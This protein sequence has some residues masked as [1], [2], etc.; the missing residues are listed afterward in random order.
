MDQ[1]I[2]KLTQ[3]IEDLSRRLQVIEQKESYGLWT[4]VDASGAALVITVGAATYWRYAQLV[5]AHFAITMP[6][7]ASAVQ[8]KIGGLPAKA[9]NTGWNAHAVCLSLQQHGA[10]LTGLVDNDSTN[11]RFADAAGGAITN[12]AYSGKQ[13]RGVAIYRTR[14]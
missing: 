7:T 2:A 4:P 5:V 10:A 9:E 14:K 1:D 6:V 12:A 3:T 11:M 13:L 8:M